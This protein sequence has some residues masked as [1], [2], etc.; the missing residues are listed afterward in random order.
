MTGTVLQVNVSRGGIP[1]Q[2][3]PS[4]VLTAAGIDGDV[5]LLNPIT[6]ENIAD[7]VAAAGL[8][9]RAEAAEIIAALYE[10]ARDRRT[11][12]SIARVV[13]AWG[14]RTA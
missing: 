1:K 4:G 5:K 7:A 3:I 9:S 10:C 8:A 2:A 11:V 14:R 13:Q 12:M 6:M